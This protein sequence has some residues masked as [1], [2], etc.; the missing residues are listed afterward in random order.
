MLHGGILAF[1]E[2]WESF[3]AELRF[4]VLDELHAYRRHLRQS[5]PARGPAAQPPLR[6]L[7]ERPPLQSP[8]RPPS[9]IR[10]SSPP[11]SATANS[12]RS[13]KAGHRR[14][15]RHFLF[16]NPPES[17]EHRG[18]PACCSWA[19]RRDS[20]PSCSRGP[21]VVT[22]SSSTAGPRRR[23]PT[24]ATASA[25]TA[26]GTCRRSAARSKPGWSP[27]TCSASSPPRR[28][29]SASISGG[30]T[31]AC[32]SATRGAS[33]NT[34]Q[35]AGRVGAFR[36][37]VAGAPHRRPRRPSI[38]SSWPTR[39]TSSSAGS[40]TPSPT[41]RTATSSRTTSPARRANCRLPRTNRSTPS[42][43]TAKPSTSSPPPEPCCAAPTGTPGSRR[44]KQPHRLVSMR[45]IGESWSIVHG[46][47]TIGSVSGGQLY[48]ECY[49]GAI[50]LHRGRQY[51]IGERNP[52][53]TA[54]RGRGGRR[55]LVQPAPSTKRRRRSSKSS[56]P[57]RC[58]GTWPGWGGCWSAHR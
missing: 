3:L 35:R 11:G 10:P 47:R 21:G 28:W 55:P 38:S 43:A 34:W 57:G 30:S 54:D 48:G 24:C 6:S 41:P 7:R 53:Q 16:L 45:S 4:I 37:R 20:A 26:P 8:A 23:A 36:A 2:T 22:E 40:R 33:S 9:A 14:R 52:R 50:Y 56:A 42:T 5:R 12:P 29:S 31:S 32:W 25:R 13:P 58:T 49:E 15:A 27:A 18:P 44:G 17:P 19:C 1:R 39:G 51:L 46:R